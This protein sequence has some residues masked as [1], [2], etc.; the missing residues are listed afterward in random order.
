MDSADGQPA[1][2]VSDAPGAEALLALRLGFVPLVRLLERLTP[3]A[4]RVGARQFAIA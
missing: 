4:V 1:A 3:D 2:A